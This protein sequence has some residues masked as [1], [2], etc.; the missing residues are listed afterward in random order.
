MLAVCAVAASAVSV[1]VGLLFSSV[2]S[3]ITAADVAAAIVFETN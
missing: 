2:F 1:T 3:G